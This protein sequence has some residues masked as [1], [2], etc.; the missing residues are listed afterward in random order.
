MTIGMLDKER[1][2]E[3][4]SCQLMNM[5]RKAGGKNLAVANGQR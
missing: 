1:K 5:S 3:Q 4:K 2:Q